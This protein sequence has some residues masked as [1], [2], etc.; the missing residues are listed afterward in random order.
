[1]VATLGFLTLG[2]ALIY[3]PMALAVAGY[4]E[5][6]WSVIN[7][8]VG[9]D[10]IRRMGLVYVKAFFMYLVVQAAGISAVLFVAALTA[11]LTLPLLGN[12]P[13]RIIG[14]V[15]TFYCSL[16]VAYIL[17]RSLHECAPQLNIPTD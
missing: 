2:W 13:G 7:P 14:G 16:A 9:L 6:F 10:T 15:I 5:D 12:L 4:S 11:P 17:G 8:T 3:Y 1:M